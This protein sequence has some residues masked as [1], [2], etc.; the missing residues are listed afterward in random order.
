MTRTD[1]DAV[2]FRAVFEKSSALQMLLD[3]S[4]VIVAVSD[5]YAKATLT[6]REKIVGR[7]LFEVFPDN[8][9]Y[10]HAD[11]VSNL[12]R[13]LLKVVQTRA[14]DAM[15]VQK[16]DIPRPGGSFEERWWKPVNWPI[17]GKD[18]FVSLIVHQ[19]EDVTESVRAGR[20]RA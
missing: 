4:F 3:T 16:Y 10:D 11:G 14:A 13:S 20:V 1:I 15:P 18:G 12:R 8:P 19:V 7:H 5:A 2:D 6:E 17:L 9:D